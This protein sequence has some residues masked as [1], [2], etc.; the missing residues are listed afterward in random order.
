MNGVVCGK[1]TFVCSVLSSIIIRGVCL[2]WDWLR[3]KIPRLTA[4]A[5]G[6]GVWTMALI[7]AASKGISRVIYRNIYIR[8]ESRIKQPVIDAPTTPYV[9]RY[10]GALTAIPLGA[11]N[12]FP[13]CN[14]TCTYEWLERRIGIPRSGIYYTITRYI[15]TILIA[16][17][18]CLLLYYVRSCRGGHFN[19]PPSLT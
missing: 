12:P 4:P 14:T 10:D 17:F 13:E 9:C 11:R 19:L 7:A 1:C 2:C 5:F 18:P 16:F 3:G 8:G 6:V 15:S